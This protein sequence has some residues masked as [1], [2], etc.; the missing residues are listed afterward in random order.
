M[1]WAGLGGNSQGTAL[2]GYGA[3]GNTINQGYANNMNRWQAGQQQ[4]QQM[5]SNIMGVAGMATGAWGAEGG[6]VGHYAEGGDVNRYYAEGD[7]VASAGMQPQ[8]TPM[9]RTNAMQP[10]A[11]RIQPFNGTI[12]QQNMQGQRP[13]MQRGPVQAM[14]GLMPPGQYNASMAEGG[15]V[16]KPKLSMKERMNKGLLL[17]SMAPENSWAGGQL[18]AGQYMDALSSLR[19]EDWRD[20]PKVAS[21]VPQDSYSIAQRPS[22]DISGSLPQAMQQGWQP[23]Q[24][25]QFM[26]E[27]GHAQGPMRAR[28]VIPS[29]QARDNI[30]A[31]LAEGEYVL[32]ADVVRALGIEKLDKMVAK[33]HRDNA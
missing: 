24:Q 5:I 8:G 29:R 30:P 17:A 23:P 28:G 22:M 25:Q 18:G 20:K 16:P 13:A 27:G 10:M 12:A 19:N 9:G 7:L 6:P 1:S 14:G 33:Y 32:P 31:Y 11:N 4:S 3:A 21:A 26:A 2:S 15:K